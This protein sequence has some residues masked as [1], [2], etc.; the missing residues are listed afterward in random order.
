M[1][2]G[3]LGDGGDLVRLVPVGEPI[4]EPDPVRDISKNWYCS[5]VAYPFALHADS[6]VDSGPEGENVN[7]E[8]SN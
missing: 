1:K 2:G 3:S 5:S 4:P 8:T 6:Y 7:L